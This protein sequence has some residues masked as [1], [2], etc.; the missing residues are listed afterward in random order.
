MGG[1]CDNKEEHFIF[2]H[3]IP[4]ILGYDIMEGDI[5]EARV[6]NMVIQSPN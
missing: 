6:Y 5:M 1:K 4:R 2:A 3:L